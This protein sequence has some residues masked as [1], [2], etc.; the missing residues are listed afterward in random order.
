MQHNFCLVELN[1]EAHYYIKIVWLL[2][3]ALNDDEGDDDTERY[4]LWGLW[5]RRVNVLGLLVFS[6]NIKNMILEMILN[7]E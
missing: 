2:Q 5:L 4:A 3:S 7:V 6:N 1:A